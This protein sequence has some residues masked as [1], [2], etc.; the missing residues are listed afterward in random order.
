M[1]VCFDLRHNEINI[2]GEGKLSDFK[3]KEGY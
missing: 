1:D 2:T 3:V